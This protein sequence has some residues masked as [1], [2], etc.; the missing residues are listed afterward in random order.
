M[1]HQTNT[2]SIHIMCLILLLLALVIATTQA[3]SSARNNNNNCKQN[4]IS[5]KRVGS[6]AHNI[7]K[8]LLKYRSIN[9]HDED[10]YY[11]NDI[12]PRT[13]E[14]QLQEIDREDSRL[15]LARLQ[16]ADFD[17]PFTLEQGL[18]TS[19]SSSH[20]SISDKEDEKEDDS[21]LV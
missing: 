12:H 20:K 17:T 11:C 7:H 14:L 18:G 19:A 13:H 15:I 9:I 6:R 8:S 3:F 10:E 21:S 16:Q 4:P 2:K 1:H 5:T